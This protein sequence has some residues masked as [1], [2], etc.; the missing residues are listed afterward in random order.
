MHPA[1]YKKL[2]H[3]KED[4]HLI[5]T[6]R[7]VVETHIRN[8]I[9][10]KKLFGARFSGSPPDALKDM[11]ELTQYKIECMEKTNSVVDDIIKLFKN[12]KIEF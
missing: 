3:L 4:L 5:Q 2:K 10:R 1:F 12:N 6:N 11:I 9:A 8:R 7:V